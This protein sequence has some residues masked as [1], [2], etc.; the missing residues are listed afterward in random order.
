MVD[1]PQGARKKA[2]V[3]LGTDGGVWRTTDGG[4]TCV[5]LTDN[6]ASFEIGALA[7]DSSNPDVVYADQY[8][9]RPSNR[10]RA[11][12]SLQRV[13]FLLERQGRGAF[14]HDT[15]LL[16]NFL[17]RFFFLPLL[18]IDFR[19]AQMDFR[20]LGVGLRCPLESS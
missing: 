9:G 15:Q 13:E 7:L 2:G 1:F 20:H 4:P 14:G 18:E 19:Q 3:Y 8:A 17:A 6:Q 16:V 11:D 12:I 10:S 5:P